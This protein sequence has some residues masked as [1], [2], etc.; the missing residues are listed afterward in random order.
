M[1]FDIKFVIVLYII[2]V[3]LLFLYKNEIFDLNVKNKNKKMIYLTF[4]LFILAIISFYTKVI[5]ECFF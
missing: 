5:L 3:V 2:L 4:L 1:N